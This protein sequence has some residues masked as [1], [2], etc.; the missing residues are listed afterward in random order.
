MSKVSRIAIS[1]AAPLLTLS[2]A[3]ISTSKSEDD[4]K[5][6]YNTSFQYVP[7]DRTEVLTAREKRRK[8]LQC[9]KKAEAESA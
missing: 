7:S 1:P 5:P 2:L 3:K 8:V 6:I 9:P 4:E